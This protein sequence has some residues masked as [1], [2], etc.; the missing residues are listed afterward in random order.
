MY[1]IRSF[2]GRLNVL[3]SQLAA[4]RNIRHIYGDDSFRLVLLFD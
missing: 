4:G 1:A 3:V 2:I